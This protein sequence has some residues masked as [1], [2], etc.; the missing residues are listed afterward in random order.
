MTR[1]VID[2]YRE[3][4]ERR[5]MQ[6]QIVP[7]SPEQYR[8][9]N[10]EDG[11]AMIDTAERALTQGCCMFERHCHLATLA[12]RTPDQAREAVRALYG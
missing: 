11:L 2:W 12:G 10:L 8:R 7:S 6:A 5:E 4:Q 1:V 3:D 9:W